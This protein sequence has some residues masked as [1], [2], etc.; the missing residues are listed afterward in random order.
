[1][2][3]IQE[4]Y[5]RHRDFFLLLILFVTFHLLALLL[6]RP[7]GYIADY[8]DYNTS[9]LPFAR[10]SDQGLYPFIHYWLEWPPLFPWLVVGVYRLSLL[11][12]PWTDPRLWYNTLLGMALLPFEVGNLVLVYLL[13]RE[14]Y[15]KDKAIKCAWIYALLFTPLYI[16][17]GWFDPLPLFFLLLG[18]YLILK[19]R[20]A[21]AGAALGVGFMVKVAPAVILAVGLKALSPWRRKAAMLLAFGVIVLLIALPFLIMAPQYLL[22]SFRIM[23]ERPP[24]ETVWAIWE[25]NYSYGIV[26]GD[27]FDPQAHL[28]APP[29]ALPW[30]L[31]TLA[32]GLL[33]LWL[34]SRPLD[35]DKGRLLAFAGLTVNLFTLY[36]K[37]Y[38]PQ[39]LVQLIPFIV[40]L[41]PNLRGVVYI[42]LLDL[43]NFLEGWVYFIILP[44]ERWL[45]VATV[46]ARS[47]LLLLLCGEY[48]IVALG[49]TFRGVEALRRRA[50][51]A[52]V[53]AFLL[54]GMVG[55]YRL[56]VAYGT[57]RY[58][59]EEYRPVVEFLRRT[60]EPGEAVF[61]LPDHS[62]YRRLYP[63]LRGEMALYVIDERTL[64][65][66]LEDYQD[67]WL[68]AT[69]GDGT[70]AWLEARFPLMAAYD[71]EGARLLHFTR[72]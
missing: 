49:L 25:G 57:S 61:L 50:S 69:E 67:I 29:S 20:G 9:Y 31:I 10:W 11:F 16:W 71:F 70:Q 28:N 46:A 27:R 1:M 59:Q 36:S 33:Y 58:A 68:W 63:Y 44:Q 32:F 23:M 14:L 12:P 55:G 62:L 15:E 22:A 40:L 72:K 13:A 18:L 52:L 54:G 60:V 41:L 51:V 8:S 48:L 34:F 37:G 56:A 7:G 24:W 53:V 38:S 5:N 19:G 6:L 47:L 45:L 35:R 65:Q 2:R 42:L 21:A 4:A 17:S 64:P 66:M 26:A 39:F 43:L 30:P 3:R